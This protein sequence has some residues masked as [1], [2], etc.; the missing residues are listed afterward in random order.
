[1]FLRLT[2]LLL[3]CLRLSLLRSCSPCGR[4]ELWRGVHVTAAADMLRRQWRCIFAKGKP[5]LVIIG[6][7]GMGGG[8]N[9]MTWVL[10]MDW[11]Q[12]GGW[13]RRDV[14]LELEIGVG[15]TESDW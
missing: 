8:W 9:V 11:G 3:L 15:E 2:L 12:D 5:V 1:M 6:N 10:L 14:E 4:R 13:R 7:E